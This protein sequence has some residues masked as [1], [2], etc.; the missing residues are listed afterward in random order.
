MAVNIEEVK[1]DKTKRCYNCKYKTYNSESEE[2]Q[3]WKEDSIHDG[4]T[5]RD[6]YGCKYF[7]YR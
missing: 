2:Y 7:E 6:R 1:M 4:E 5:I 3:C